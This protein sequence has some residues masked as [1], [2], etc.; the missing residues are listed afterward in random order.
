MRR[1]RAR[2]HT[3]AH[4][5]GAGRGKGGIFWLGRAILLYGGSADSVNDCSISVVSDNNLKLVTLAVTARTTS[6]DDWA[7]AWPGIPV[8]VSTVSRVLEPRLTDWLT[9]TSRRA[10][11]DQNKVCHRSEWQTL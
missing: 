7:S 11:H 10:R 2:T 8:A 9:H 6:V 1:A 3:H 4:A 5:H